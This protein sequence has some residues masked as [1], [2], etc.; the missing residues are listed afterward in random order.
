MSVSQA[1]RDTPTSS[2][3]ALRNSEP[4]TKLDEV[5]EFDNL[6]I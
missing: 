4:G 6:I 3:T 1:K 2:V 5:A